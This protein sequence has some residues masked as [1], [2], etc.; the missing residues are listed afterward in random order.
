MPERRTRAPTSLSDPE[1]VILDALRDHAE[2]CPGH[3]ISFGFL[4]DWN[5]LIRRQ[6]RSAIRTLSAKGHVRF[7]AAGGGFVLTEA[8]HLIADARRARA[9]AA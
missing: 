7:D 2:T 5:P 9:E 3:A 1:R 6:L 4:S 8:G